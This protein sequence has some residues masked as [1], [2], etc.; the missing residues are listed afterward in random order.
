MF[1]ERALRPFEHR[2]KKCPL[3]EF[4]ETYGVINYGSG[5]SNDVV[6]QRL[7]FERKIVYLWLLGWVSGLS[8]VVV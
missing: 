3:A 6:N 5:W 4:P 7:E 8:V 2:R 1:G